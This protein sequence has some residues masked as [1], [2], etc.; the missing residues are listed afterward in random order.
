MKSIVRTFSF[1]E[2]NGRQLTNIP[3]TEV[4]S[5]REEEEEEE[6]VVCM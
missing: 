1:Q 4:V 2:T 3:S 6:E 5:P